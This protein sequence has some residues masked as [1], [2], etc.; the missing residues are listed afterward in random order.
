MIEI[1]RSLFIILVLNI[2]IGCVAAPHTFEDSLDFNQTETKEPTLSPLQIYVIDVGQ[3]DAT[4]IVGPDG[5]TLLIDGGPPET[6]SEAVLDFLEEK[7]ISKIDWILATHYDL[8]H[9][10]GFSEILDS[11]LPTEALLDRGDNTDQDH[12]LFNSYL[13]KA[14]SLRRTVEVGEAIDLGQGA[15]ATV[16]V[17]NGR[18]SDGSGIHLNPDEENESSIG[19]LIEYRNFQYFTAGDL[20]G[21]GKTGFE[22]TK[23]LESEVARRIGDTDV[24]H[25]GHHGSRTSTNQNLIDQS[26]PEVAVISVGR[27]NHYGHPAPEVLQRLQKAQIEIYRTDLQGNIEITTAGG[28]YKIIPDQIN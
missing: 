26:Q 3:G 1:M 9:I 5:T 20:T 28:S 22:E 7:K 12:P 4:L 8:D 24:L 6:G 25:V 15:R 16:V 14:G 10:G 27:D 21:G 18:F 19:L 11:F 13:E 2:A 17:T 23:D